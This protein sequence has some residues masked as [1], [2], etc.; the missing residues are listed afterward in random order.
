MK[1]IRVALFVERDV[2]E[3]FGE[4]CKPLSRSDFLTLIMMKFIGRLDGD[5]VEQAKGISQ[6][7][8]GKHLAATQRMMAGCSD[9]ATMAGFGSSLPGG[10]KKSKK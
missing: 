2:W 3:E 4:R 8:Q 10:K 5:L 6:V 9:P 7:L 1:R